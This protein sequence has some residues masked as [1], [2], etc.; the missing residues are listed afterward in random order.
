MRRLIT[1]LFVSLLLGLGCGPKMEK[2]PRRMNKEPEPPPAVPARRNVPIDP[3][4]QQEAKKELMTAVESSDPLIRAH[5]I[6]ALRDT[7]GV[8]AAGT[9]IKHLSDDGAIVRFASAVAAGELRLA[10]AKSTLLVM[11]DDADPSVQIGAKFALHRLGDT[12]QSHDLER[13]AIDMN[14]RTRGDTAM[15][16]GLLG[17][18]SAVKILAPM[19]YDKNEAVRLQ[20]AE[21]LWRLGDE[22]GLNELVGAS[23]SQF[24][25]LQM[26][27]IL[28][29]AAPRDRRALG[30]IEGQLTGT[31]DEV[32]LIAARAA[33]ML[34]SDAGYGVALKG[35][36]SPLARQKTLAAL[37]FGA[38]GR[39]DAQE[40]LAPLLKDADA[41]VRL[42][43]AKALLQLK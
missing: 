10:Q 14:P 42:C 33:G 11:S 12:R 18:P 36:K 4:L 5:A 40:Y 16:L 20:A 39:P 38:I 26:V 37:A 21:A 24:P 30:H 3:T 1:T 17:E 9:I 27:A 35:I 22:R 23:I 28:G 6:E 31:Y 32:N 43:A 7:L 19:I 25:D 41:D 15:V 13:T 29:L 8:D 34:G 2:T